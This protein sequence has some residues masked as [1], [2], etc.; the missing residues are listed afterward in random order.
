MKK[1]LKISF[2][3]IL[4]LMIP[5]SFMFGQDKKNEQKIKIIVNDGS[6]TKV[7]I[8]TLFSGD[9]SPDSLT[10][11]DGSVVHLKHHGGEGKHFFVTYSSDNK[12]D[13]GLTKEMT[14]ISDD[15][16]DFIKEDHPNV[17]Y[18]RNDRDGHHRY[19]VISLSGDGDDKEEMVIVNR[20]RR[21]GEGSEDTFDEYVSDDSGV[22]KTRFVIAKDGMVV[23]IESTD[24]AKAKD[25]AKEIEQKLGVSGQEEKKV[26]SK[27]KTQK[28]TV[29]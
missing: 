2:F 27:S 5:F 17:M 4:F 13:K 7:I 6:D 3:A 9:N 20:D 18:Y 26:V 24:E 21:G 23:T 1:K 14:V 28:K 29:K 8:D 16:M 11:K 25:L 19:K 10:L 15:S 12:D 22:E